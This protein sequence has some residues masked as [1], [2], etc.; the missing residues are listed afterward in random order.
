[1]ETL[2]IIS[3]AQSGIYSWATLSQRSILLVQALQAAAAG[4]DFKPDNAVKLHV[5]LMWSK[6]IPSSLPPWEG[7]DAEV[8]GAKILGPDDDRVVVLTV[9]SDKIEAYARAAYAAG[10]VFSFSP[11]IPHITIG[12]VLEGDGEDICNRL[13]AW[14]Q[15]TAPGGAGVH[16]NQVLYSFLEV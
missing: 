11:F 4:P 1:M 15:E 5:T 12:K 16:L 10:A 13:N 3:D 9:K 2:K 6:T 14:L 7:D 8:L